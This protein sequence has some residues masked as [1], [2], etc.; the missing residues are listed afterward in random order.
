VN[1]SGAAERVA[2]VRER[3]AEAAHL[4]GRSPEAVTLVA[5]TKT[6]GV[7]VIQEACECGLRHFGENRIEEA[8]PKIQAMRGALPPDVTW[9]MVGHIQ[10]RK[11]RD[12]ALWCDVVHS[13]DRVKIVQRLSSACAEAG[14]SLPVLL[15]INLSG[16]ETKYGFDL[17]RWPED[18]AQARAFYN[19]VE[20]ALTCPNTRIVGLMTMPPLT[21][22]PEGGR[23][24]FARLRALRETLAGRFPQAAWEHLS[25]G[26]SG[27]YEVAIEEGATMVR[28]GTALFGPREQMR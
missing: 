16:E 27:D 25:M 1:V 2:Q 23:P 28:V 4:S 7:E 12:V 13:A 11:A 8:V 10:S 6:H 22:D 5:V 15:E 17:S 21:E 19:D 24:I 14:R 9:H 18:D 26:M 3:I 20:A